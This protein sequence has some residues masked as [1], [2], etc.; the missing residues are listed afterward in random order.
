MNIDMMSQEEKKEMLKH[1]YK[2]E[3]KLVKEVLEELSAEV[4]D[5]EFEMTDSEK[6]EIENIIDDHFSKYDSVFKALA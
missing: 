1:I 3:G 5:Q 4:K 6:S 2:S